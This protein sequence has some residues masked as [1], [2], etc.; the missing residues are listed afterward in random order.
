[1]R[2]PLLIAFNENTPAKKDFSLRELQC[3]KLCEW[4]TDP[5]LHMNTVTA[6][7]SGRANQ[8]VLLLLEETLT[9]SSRQNVIFRVD[10]ALFMCRKWFSQ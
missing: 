7:D 1:M 2:F 5:N 6:A 8:I 9:A 4:G 10:F 3:R